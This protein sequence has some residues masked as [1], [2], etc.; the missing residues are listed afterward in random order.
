[1][2]NRLSNCSIISL[3]FSILLVSTLVLFSYHG[4]SEDGVRAIIRTSAR[5]SVILFL[6]SFSAS[7]LHFLF[8]NSVTSTLLNS[9]RDFGISFALAH[10]WHLGAIVTLGI[11]Y[12]DPFL[13]ELTLFT[14]IAGG[15]AY[16][17]ILLMLITS[18]DAIKHR[19]KSGVWKF[20]HII[21]SYYLLISFANSYFP[22]AIEQINYLPFALMISLV[23]LLKANKIF[24]GYRVKR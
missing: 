9:R 24:I 14:L 21:G 23:L 2:K 18:F 6:L 20:I 3:V 12:P 1:M 17:F 15:L 7:S 22:R 10:F 16:L 13:S 11:L 19:I 4:I 8:K 5:C